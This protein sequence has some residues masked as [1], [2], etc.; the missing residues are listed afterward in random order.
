[1]ATHFGAWS[2]WDDVEAKL[3]GKPVNLEISLALE[4][5]PPERVR[6]MILAHPAGWLFFGSDSPWGNPKDLLAILLGLNLPESLMGKIL[7]GNAEKLLS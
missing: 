7:N 4:F 6:R 3:I 5:L 1:L 2:D